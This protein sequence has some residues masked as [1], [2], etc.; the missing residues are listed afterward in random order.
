M[1]PD[2]MMLFALFGAVF[3]MLVWGGSATIWWRSRR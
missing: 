1:T 2:Q 3:A